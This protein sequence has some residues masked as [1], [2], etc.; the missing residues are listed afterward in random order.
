M[1][2]WKGDLPKITDQGL[3]P[4]RMLALC[5]MGPASPDNPSHPSGLGQPSPSGGS[6]VP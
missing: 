5:L 3:L 4:P 2:Q 6:M 1:G